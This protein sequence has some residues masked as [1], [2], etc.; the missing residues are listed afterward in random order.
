MHE[1]RD[2]IVSTPEDG[3]QV[4]HL[5]RPEA[6]NALRT[7]LLA[8]ID[9]ALA[10]AE[11]DPAVRCVVI[12]GSEQ[13]FAA[14]ADIQEMAALDTI[15]VLEDKRVAYWANVRRFTKPIVA[16]VNGFALGGGCELAMHADII[17]AGRNARFGQP[18]INLGIIP[19][20]G[21]TQRLIRSVGK[22]MAMKMVLSGEPID[23]ETALSIGLIS[24][25]TEPELTLETAVALART[26]AR[27]PPLALRLAKQSLLDAY[28][29]TLE[30][31]LNAER[32]AFTVLAASE[33]RQ[34]G[35]QAFF[36]KRQPEFRGR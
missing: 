13:V 35:I 28:E 34:E 32:R 4:L 21:G 24:D 26:I 23:A 36:D 22:S 2:I 12:T 31:G 3:V 17:V 9:R 20:A 18:E 7:A 8:E 6:R 11:D 1:W 5:N 27:K 10:A 14:G 33:D 19:G 15:G 30:A 25:I 16:A 29:T